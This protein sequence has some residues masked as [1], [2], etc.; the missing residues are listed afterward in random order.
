[1][2]PFLLLG[3]SLADQRQ[4]KIEEMGELG[5]KGASYGLGGPIRLRSTSEKEELSTPGTDKLTLL[6]DLVRED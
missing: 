2:E 6:P 3:M 1:M 4:R 5:G